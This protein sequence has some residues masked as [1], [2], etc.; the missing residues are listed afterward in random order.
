MGTADTAELP[1]DERDDFL[2]TGGTGVLSLSTPDGDPPH[3]LPVSFGYDAVETAFYF[4]LATGG[5][6]E[7]G[8]L[9]GRAVTFVTHGEREGVHCSVVAQGRL[10]STTDEDIATEALAGLD[11][12]HIPYVDVFGKPTAE[13]SFSFVRLDPTTLTTR[14]ESSTGT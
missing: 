9:D 13:V 10:A 5:D 7:K 4:R 14:R 12:V 11:R 1:P 2:G 8:T 6:S 3:A